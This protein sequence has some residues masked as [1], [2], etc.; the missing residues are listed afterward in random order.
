VLVRRLRVSPRRVREPRVLSAPVRRLLE[1]LERWPRYLY[2]GPAGE[3]WSVVHFPAELLLLIRGH[4]RETLEAVW[5]T[6]DF[7]QDRK[8]VSSAFMPWLERFEKLQAV[9][10]WR[11]LYIYVFTIL[12]RRLV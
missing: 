12:R 8:I 10:V 4:S 6:S 1:M 9:T 3:M 5:L 7:D 2:Q 11:D